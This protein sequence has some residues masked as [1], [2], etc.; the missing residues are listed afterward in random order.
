MLRRTLCGTHARPRAR[1]AR[2]RRTPRR[3][4]AARA[5]QLRESRLP[6][7]ARRARQAL[8]DAAP[9]VVAKFY[10]PARWSDAQIL[11]EH[12]FVA[13]LAAREIPVVA[14]LARGGDD[15]ASL[16]RLPLRGLSA[17][18]AAALPSSRIARRSNGSAA[19]SAAST[20]S[21]RP[22][23]SASGRRSTSRRFGDEPRDWLLA[24]GFIPPDLVAAWTQRRR[25]GARTACGTA[26]SAPATSATLRLHGD[27]HAGNV[28][29]RTAD[30]CK[31]RISSIS[32]MPQR[33]RG[34]GPVDAAVGRPRRH[35]R[36][37]RAV[38]AGYEDFCDF[39]DRELHLVEALRTLRLIHYSAWLARRW[40]DPAFP[41]GVPVVQHAALLAGSRSS[42]CASRSR[43]WTSRRCRSSAKSSGRSRGC[44]IGS[45][46][47][48]SGRR[49]RQHAVD[50]MQRAV[51][52]RRELGIVRDDHE[53]RARRCD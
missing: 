1:C 37:L 31:G 27:C 45:G 20:P 8:R 40:D 49:R 48:R 16:R 3:R 4:P 53:A 25:A 34:A 2:R 6:G 42:S 13:E 12:A 19:S 41:G 52:A 26:T 7:V 47:R 22:R 33:S 14:P 9:S 11:E 15:A 28:L 51:G 23:H 46:A 30:R 5:Q 50:E 38:L 36:Q 21:A 24:H 18:A 29:W 32:T 43:R 10:R 35:A 17:S 44:A 39:D